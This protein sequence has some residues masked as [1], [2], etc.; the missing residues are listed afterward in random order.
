[1][2][3]GK[4]V[5]IDSKRYQA[6]YPL[7]WAYFQQNNQRFAE[8]HKGNPGKAWYGYNYKKNHTRFGAPKLLVPA[9]AT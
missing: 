8:R 6:R 3:A 2:K 1:M 7:T 9:I 4:S 5:V